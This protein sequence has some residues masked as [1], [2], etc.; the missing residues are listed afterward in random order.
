MGL[1]KDFWIC[2]SSY[3]LAS[4]VIHVIDL[5]IVF[6]RACRGRREIQDPV[7][8]M[9]IQ[10]LLGDK[11]RSAHKEIE[12]KEAL[13]EIVARWVLQAPWEAVASQDL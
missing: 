9:E 1:R 12:V 5:L 13:T 2:L 11:D 3:E 8:R 6:Y 4:S 10:D 7:E